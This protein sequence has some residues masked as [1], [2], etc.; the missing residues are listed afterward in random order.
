VS[1][2]GSGVDDWNIKSIVTLVRDFVNSF[3]VLTFDFDVNHWIR[4]DGADGRF[5]IDLNFTGK[6]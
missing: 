3:Q 5:D 4:G 2:I 6:I 1:I